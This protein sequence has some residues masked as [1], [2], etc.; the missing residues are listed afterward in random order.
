LQR[1]DLVMLAFALTHGFCVQGLQF[2]DLDANFALAGLLVVLLIKL[3]LAGN[4]ARLGQRL[5]FVE[6]DVL[7]IIPSF[8][9][10]MMLPYQRGVELYRNSNL[11]RETEQWNTQNRPGR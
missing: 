4:L 2:S 6:L 7:L 8:I 10:S 11:G 3:A 5:W 9:G 1:R